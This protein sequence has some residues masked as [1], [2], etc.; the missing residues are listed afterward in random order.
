M[1][2]PGVGF[3]AGV[4]VTPDPVSQTLPSGSV[5]IPSTIFVP[6]ERVKTPFE[7]VTSLPCHPATLPDGEGFV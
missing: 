6:D 1:P 7:Y 5:A 3:G 4:N 2:W